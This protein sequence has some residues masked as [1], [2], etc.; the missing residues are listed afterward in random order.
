MGTGCSSD[1]TTVQDGQSRSILKTKTVP[2]MKI[3]IAGDP[4]VGKTNIFLRY[5]RNQ[6]SPLYIP[7][8]RAVI[9]NHVMKVNLP[10]HAVVSLSL[11]D[12]PG[13]EDI[14][15]YKSYF[16]DLDAAIVVVDVSDPESIMMANVWKQIVVTNIEK[17]TPPSDGDRKQDGTGTLAVDPVKFPV[18]L[19]GTK[20][21]I[22]EQRMEAEGQSLY[23][24]GKRLKDTDYSK[25]TCDD[26]EIRSAREIK[27]PACVLE[28]EKMAEEHNFVGSVMVSARDG[29]GSVHTAIQSFIR[30]IL[31]DQFMERR[32]KSRTQTEEVPD[33]NDE[34][35]ITRKLKTIG[36]EQ[37]DKA[38]GEKELVKIF[39]RIDT[40]RNL[41]DKSF[42]KFV[43]L[44]E[45]VEVI[46]HGEGS[47]ENCIVGL[48]KYLGEADF[49]LQL[50]E[51]GDVYQMRVKRLSE[52]THMSKALKN[53]LTTF[54]KEYAASG[55]AILREFPPLAE[56]LEL[57]DQK[58]A[59]TVASYEE[60]VEPG[61]PTSS[62][63]EELK[64]RS[65]KVEENRAVL[66]HYQTLASQC[67][68][69]V[70]NGVSRAKTAF[71]W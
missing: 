46:G 2:A 12:I 20:C 11:W 55:A 56:R 42:K 67:C 6:F 43:S 25:L 18:L 15:L 17:T 23:P 60:P 61:A 8:Q 38:F 27:K 44:C 13:R 68:Q 9:E 30:H 57:V 34:K 35:K 4:S 50:V 26:V 71:I 40:L 63:R 49:K 39:D 64:S 45:D 53:I 69:N 14:D 70:S 58:V 31:E 29:D 48:R 62:I 5:M 66:Q 59:V 16:R 28:L 47:I 65:A 7:T 36:I 24:Q 21:D 51:K 54:N 19:L 52:D 3:V 37:I 41:N 33:N 10:S 1:R 32:W 22:V